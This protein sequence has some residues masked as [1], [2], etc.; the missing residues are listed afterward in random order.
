VVA[1][2]DEQIQRQLLSIVAPPDQLQ[3]G[4]IARGREPAGVAP[5]APLE[6][7]VLTAQ[8]QQAFGETLREMPLADPLRSDEKVR[9]GQP[10][11]RQ[12][13]AE[14]LDNVV[15]SVNVQPHRIPLITY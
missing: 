2:A 12:E 13:P 11:I 15:V 8:A 14:S 1:I 10:A 9:T 3:V 6:E 5:S 7:P 4:M